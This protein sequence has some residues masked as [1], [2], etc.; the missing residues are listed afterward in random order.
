MVQQIISL[1]DITLVWSDWTPW[2]Q[3]ALPAAESGLSIPDQPGVYEV[4]TIHS[5]ERLTIGKASSLRR[6]VR[7]HLVRGTGKHSTGKRI[8]AA[9]DPTNLLVRW[10]VTDRPAAVEEELHRLYLEANGKQ[11]V[12]TRSTH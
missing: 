7:I 8:R 4:K 2:P 10:A 12:Y 11:P 9:E 3:I 1:P 6:R 5:E